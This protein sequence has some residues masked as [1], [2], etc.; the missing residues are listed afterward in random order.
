MTRTPICDEMVK[1]FEGL[2][3]R[4]YQDAV[5]VWTVGYGHT[6]G[7]VK[8]NHTISLEDANYFLDLDLRVATAGVLGAIK[9][10]TESFTPWEL[11]ALTSFVF[12]VGVGAFSNST[13]LKLILAGNKREAAGQFRRWKYAGGIPLEGLIRRRRAEAVRFLGGDWELVNDVYRLI[14][15]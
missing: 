5:G 7:D 6:G 8:P 10:T 11:D 3:L 15:V 13:M 1:M 12:N 14:G 4:S 2:R 9:G